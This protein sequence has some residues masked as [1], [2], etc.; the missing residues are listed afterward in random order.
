MEVQCCAFTVVAGSRSP[1]VGRAAWGFPRHSL[2]LFLSTKETEPK[3]VNG[4][5]QSYT[6]GKDD[7]QD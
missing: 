1:G 2:D 6:P 4:F 7:K 5:I 3:Q